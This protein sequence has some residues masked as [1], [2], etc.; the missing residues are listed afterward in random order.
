MFPL[1]AT[2]FVVKFGD[3]WKKHLHPFEPLVAKW[4]NVVQIFF[5]KS[6]HSATHKICG[7]KCNHL[8]QLALFLQVNYFHS[9]FVKVKFSLFN[10]R[11][12]L[13]HLKGKFVISSSLGLRRSVRMRFLTQTR[14]KVGSFQICSRLNI[15][16]QISTKHN[17]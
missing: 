12:L 8:S 5:H 2:Y 10:E 9:T 14:Q 7:A 16:A 6:P 17:Y 3:F 13:S 1:G 11:Q 4:F 15:Y